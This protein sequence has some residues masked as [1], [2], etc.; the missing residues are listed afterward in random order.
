MK[1]FLTHLSPRL[2]ITI[3]TQCTA[4]VYNARLRS[5]STKPLCFVMLL[6]T[7]MLDLFV[8]TGCSA[9]RS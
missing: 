7:I 2:I 5:Q 6:H 3:S 8:S 1:A 9:G 4:H